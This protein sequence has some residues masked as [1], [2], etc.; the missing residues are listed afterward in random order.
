MLDETWGSEQSLYWGPCRGDAPD[1]RSGHED[2][3]NPSCCVAYTLACALFPGI[4][5]RAK[6][7]QKHDQMI[8]DYHR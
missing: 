2:K 7:V 1:V 3:G 6:L 5:M 4:T 8:D